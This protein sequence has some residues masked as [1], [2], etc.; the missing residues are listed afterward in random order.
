META[1]APDD[2]DAE[3]GFL[4]TNPPYGERLGDREEA[5]QTYQAMGIL[6]QHFPGWKLVVITNHP[7]FESFFGRRASS[8]KNITNG[9]LKSYLY[10]YEY[11]GRK[12]N[13]DHRRT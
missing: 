12:T 11:L 6:E 13:V 5:E 8:V 3:G 4:V 9:A 2:G 10:Q 7:G 1:K